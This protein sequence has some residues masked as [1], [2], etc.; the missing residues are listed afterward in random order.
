[1]K[2][3]LFIYLYENCSVKGQWKNQQIIWLMVVLNSL[4]KE[5]ERKVGDVLCEENFTG[6]WTEWWIL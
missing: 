1:M 6:V 2:T 4:N 3:Y 5:N